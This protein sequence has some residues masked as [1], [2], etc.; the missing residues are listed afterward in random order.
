MEF[1]GRRFGHIR[2]TDVVGKGGMGD[3]YVG[4]DEKL[5]R[6]VALKVLH[7]ENRLDAESRERLLREAR[8]LS[9][10]DHPNIC[11]IHDYIESNDVDV[12]VLEY[13]DGETLQDAVRDRQLSRAERLR[14]ALAV[15]DSLVAV[16]RVGI[17]HRDLKPEN[18]M[19][20]RNGVVKVLDFGLA[21][22]LHV[23]SSSGKRLRAVGSAEI[24]EHFL[25]HTAMGITMG[26]PLYMSP[27]QARG[28]ELTTASDMYALGLFLQFLFTGTDPHP[29]G[30]TA[31][32]VILRASRGETAEM[33]GVPGD[34]AA[35]VARLQQ[36]APADRPTA[37]ETVARL[38]HFMEKP[39]RLMRGAVIAVAVLLVALASWRYTADLARERTLAVGARA[40]A[41]A[42]RAQ[43]EDL[44]EYM[45][46]DLRKKLDS[47]GRL[48]ILDD[49]GVR[50]LS[51][52]DSVDPAALS[53]SDL[54]RNA[55]ALNHLGEV[56]LAQG[57]T[58]EA[59]ALFTRSL[60]LAGDAIRR[61]PRNAEALLVH[62]AAHF[63][64]GNA[65]RLQ[66]TYDDALVHMR[67]YM[68]DG[69]TLSEIDP[70]NRTYQLE[71]AYGHTA[72][73]QVLEEK[74]ELLPA[75][76]RYETSLRIKSRIVD[77]NPD[78]NDAQ[79]DLARAINKVGAAQYK[80]G[81]FADAR[82]NAAREVAIYRRLL[83]R[84]PKQTQWKYRLATA[85][86]Y[87]ANAKN[88][89]GDSA[90][91]VT[92]WREELG[93]ERE[94]AAVDPT[95]IIWQRNVAITLR[96]LADARRDAGDRSA[97]ALYAESRAK[98]APLIARAPAQTSLQYDL[99]SID[100]EYAHALTNFG[101]AG[102]A[103]PLLR[104]VLQQSAALT[105]DRNR[106]QRMRAWCYLGEW[107][108]AQSEL[109]A[110]RKPPTDP[111]DLKL[112]SQLC[113]QIGC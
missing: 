72:V 112:A 48:D 85:I 89:T 104:N 20:T 105:D 65:L 60:K 77:A 35:L 50:A 91:A 100:V 46:G 55:K 111:A 41:E 27:E 78:D 62:G 40:E 96:R 102:R 90:G 23:L 99:R 18:V 26:T 22:W 61:E 30:L 49:I 7:S 47:V 8:T 88:A 28:E 70:E 74:G 24:P 53:T 63:W 19:L 76:D 2:I 42:R 12:L 45:L 32:E 113:Q 71:R 39:N 64:I 15:T 54:A 107:R 59:S 87:L 36:F 43:A 33:R 11:R 69:D 95:N 16:H 3:V 92:L 34:V 68:K 110:L 80:V 25:R 84:E 67:A 44:I 51:Y 58:Q 66:G 82:E 106:L 108:Q 5:D 37:V 13:I 52:V 10:L 83:V 79:A 1:I 97:L 56:R 75:L 17:I 4:Y 94:I 109:A 29:M 57:K 14:I 73:A 21:R 81:L 93:M 86:A 38:K 98:M 101:D 31:R 9:K 6:K 103:V